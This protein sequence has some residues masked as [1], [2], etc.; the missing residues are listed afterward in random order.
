MGNSKKQLIQKEIHGFAEEEVFALYKF[1]C[2]YESV[3]SKMT[4]GA[5]LVK[6]Y[7][8]LRGIKSKI[9]SS[10]R[11]TCFSRA[12]ITNFNDADITPGVFYYSAKKGR[13]QEITVLL[14]LRD[15]IA[16]GLIEKSGD[17]IRFSDFDVKTNEY[18]AKGYIEYKKVID[19]VNLINK[20]VNL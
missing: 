9:K 18:T 3:L 19:I 20:T 16:H 10:L 4:D 8:A 13:K 7:T 17:Y 14:H 5:T 2:I 15:A 11:P 1:L 12:K 6:K